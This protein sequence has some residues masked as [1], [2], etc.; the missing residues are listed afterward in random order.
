MTSKI[1]SNNYFKQSISKRIAP[2]SLLPEQKID[3]S[4]SLIEKSRPSYSFYKVLFPIEIPDF[5]TP[6][7][8]FK[9]PKKFLKGKEENSK[10]KNP[11][12]ISYLLRETTEEEKE[13]NIPK[14]KNLFDKK[15]DLKGILRVRKDGLFYLDIDDRFIHLFF[16]ILRKKGLIKPPYFSLFEIPKGAHSPVV[17]S[18]ETKRKSIID[19]DLVGSEVSFSIKG[20]YNMEPDDWEAV[21]KV[22]Y[23][24]IESKTLEKLRAWNRLSSKINGH[25][26]HIVIAICPR[27]NK[28][29]A[30]TPCM[31][32]NPAYLAV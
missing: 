1:F 20:I 30:K 21:E 10:R 29:T 23:L 12:G 31:R 15:I 5:K 24:K 18:E 7:Y 22:W 6:L 14:L 16:P 28:K 26:F 8:S 25:D 32:I 11:P 3:T 9:P 4:I 2:I 13:E 27:M 19:T 17:L